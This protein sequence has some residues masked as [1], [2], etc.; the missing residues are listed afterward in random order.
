MEETRY[1]QGVCIFFNSMSVMFTIP[2][3][4][5]SKQREKMEYIAKLYLV[6]FFL[7]SH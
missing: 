6:K 1:V 4:C 7:I 5:P 2:I 3:I